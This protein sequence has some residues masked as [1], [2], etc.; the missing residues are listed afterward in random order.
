LKGLKLEEQLKIV[1]WN[2]NGIR[3]RKDALLNWI[4][5]NQP[6]LLFLQE[7]KA[8][9]TKIPQDF[10]DLPHYK[11]VWNESTFKG[12]YSGTA[13]LYKKELI[14]KFGQI[15]TF[16]PEF[17]QENRLLV[18][19]QN[20]TVYIGIY[21]PRGDKDEHLG[22][23][24]EM[25]NKLKE[26]VAEYLNKGFGIVLC[27]DFNVAHKDIDVHE[28][29]N[30][31]NATGLRPEERQLIDG[32]LEIGLRD[33]MRERDPENNRLFTWWPYWRGARERNL[34]WRIDSFFIS[35]NLVEKIQGT[36]VDVEEKSSDHS[37]VILSLSL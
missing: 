32:F 4:K 15:D 19:I 26:F 11:A 25:L 29:Q 30:K 18:Y 31:L 2:I 16:I 9:K 5:N 21:T 36:K 17:D 10:L 7:I 37:P 27:G 8:D 3:A 33:I 14:N 13:L 20:N 35:S 23:K 6:D 24:I 28:S 12:G 22:L 34:G 1:S